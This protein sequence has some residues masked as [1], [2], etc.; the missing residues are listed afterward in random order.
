M[1]I[2]KEMKRLNDLVNERTAMQTTLHYYDRMSV[3]EARARLGFDQKNRIEIYA[4]N[5]SP[6][7]RVTFFSESFRGNREAIFMKTFADADEA[8]KFRLGFAVLAAA[9]EKR[10]GSYAILADKYIAETNL[11]VVDTVSMVAA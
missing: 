9:Q 8:H 1:K 3:G 2:T 10:V 7:Y 4:P 5:S 6:L 11:K